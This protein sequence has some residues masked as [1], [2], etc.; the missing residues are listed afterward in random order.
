MI[1]EAEIYEIGGTDWF[2]YESDGRIWIYT[3]WDQSFPSRKHLGDEI[4]SVLSRHEEWGSE[5]TNQLYRDM[6]QKHNLRNLANELESGDM[7]KREAVERLRE[8]GDKSK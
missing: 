6:V 3:D 8:L 4:Y 5:P 2:V 1:S 7:S